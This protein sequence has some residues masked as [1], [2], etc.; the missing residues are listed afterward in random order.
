M[1]AERSLEVGTIWT[2]RNVH[3]VLPLVEARAIWGMARTQD[4]GHGGRFAVWPDHLELWSKAGRVGDPGALP[5][6]SEPLGIVHVA[7]KV[8][9]DGE[10]VL[11]R[12]AWNTGKGGS[13]ALVW[14][15]LEVLAGKSLRP[16]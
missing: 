1:G 4:L 3:L 5:D 2:G 10:A 9:T 7:W 13:E 8:P 15:V 12:V 14:G 6:D 11:E 16:A